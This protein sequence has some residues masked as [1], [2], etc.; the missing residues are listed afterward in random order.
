M[1]I[2]ILG[3]QRIPISVNRLIFIHTHIF[4][5][6]PA[7]VVIEHMAKDCR[8]VL[9]L[10][11]WPLQPKQIWCCKVKYHSVLT[12]GCF[13]KNIPELM[14]ILVRLCLPSFDTGAEDWRSGN[15]QTQTTMLGKLITTCW[16]DMTQYPP[17]SHFVLATRGR[18]DALCTFLSAM[19]DLWS[20][21]RI[22]SCM[23]SFIMTL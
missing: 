10:T 3:N 2:T 6:Y 14:F 22:Q 23:F 17:F 4:P 21:V 15:I 7:D 8:K 11:K 9:S 1:L 12:W 18:W 19:T 16:R 20:K 13:C 5:S